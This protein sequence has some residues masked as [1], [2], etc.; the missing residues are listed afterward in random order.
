MIMMIIFRE[1]D[2]IEFQKLLSQYAN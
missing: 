1:I 2:R